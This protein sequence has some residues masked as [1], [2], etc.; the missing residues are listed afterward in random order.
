MTDAFKNNNAVL[1]LWPG[2]QPKTSAVKEWSST[3]LCT[4]V[5]CTCRLLRCLMFTVCLRATLAPSPSRRR[6]PTMPRP[7]G[8]SRT[9]SSAV[10][11]LALP[12][13]GVSGGLGADGA[14]PRGVEGG[15]GQSGGMFTYG[16]L[17]DALGTSVTYGGETTRSTRT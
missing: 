12:G 9:P 3:G 8:A 13:A 5:S 15:V 7:S 4:N 17:A 10:A 16:R 6:S 2:E 14:G 11:A 1:P